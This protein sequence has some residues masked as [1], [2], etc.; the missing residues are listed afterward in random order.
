MTTIAQTPTLRAEK[1]AIPR[2]VYIALAIGILAGASA[3]LATKYALADGASPLMIAFFRLGAATLL[4]TPIV[5]AR[6]RHDLR[7][8][9][10]RD[11]VLLSIGGMWMALHFVLWSASLVYASVLVATVIVCSSPIWTAVFE[12]AFLRARLTRMIAIGLI[13]AVGGN[14]AIAFGGSADGGSNQALG[15]FI[16]MVAA[17]AIAAQ[18]TIGR[19]LRLHIPVFP[20]LWLMY[21]AGTL[22]LL[23]I[24]IATRTPIIGYTPSA[25]LWMFLLTLLP[26]LLGHGAFNYA[27]GYFSA[28]FTSLII[29]MQPPIASA[30]AFFAFGEVPGWLQVIGSGV[31]VAGVVIAIQA[32]RTASGA[33]SPAPPPADADLR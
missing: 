15:G 3:A 7:K 30:V 6:Y 28:T 19:S 18:R 17:V 10:R 12:I 13:L 5:L 26:Q 31:I 27:L 1:A 24:M 23:P 25:Y 11:L 14:I 20:Y 4:L 29:Q 16:A 8:L 22:T 32:R 2:S 21:L 33:A 9:T